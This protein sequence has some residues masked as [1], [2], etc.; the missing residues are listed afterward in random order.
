MFKNSVLL[1]GALVVAALL[2]YQ[3]ID[4]G[5]SHAEVAEKSVREQAHFAA[6][7]YTRNARDFLEAKLL[8]PGLEVTAKAGGSDPSVVL[9]WSEWEATSDELGWDPQSASALF[10]AGLR[11]EMVDVATVAADTAFAARFASWV[12]NELPGQVALVE[13]EGWEPVL[14][15]IP[16]EAASVAYRLYPESRAEATLAYG[17]RVVH[18][19]LSTA[20]ALAFAEGPLLPEAV[21]GGRANAALFFVTV[22]DAEGRR[23]WASDSTYQS[24]YV[25]RDTVGTKFGG[26]TTSV[27]VNPQ[28]AP[29]LVIGGLPRQRLPLVFALLALSVGLVATA[30]VQMRR[31]SE[32]AALRADFV[33]G[34]SHELRTPLAQIRMFSETLLLGRVRSEEERQRSLEIIVN[35]SQRLTHQVDNVLLYSRGERQGTRFDPCPL[36]LD[37]LVSEVVEGFEP[38]AHA[39][40]SDLTL[41]GVGRVRL[42][43]DGALVRQ[44]LLNLLDNAVKYGR[45]EQVVIVGVERSDAGGVRI[46]VDDEGPGVSEGERSR[47]FQPYHRLPRDRESAVAGSGIGLAV[48]GEV[49]RVHGGRAWVE[50]GA[51]GGARFVIELPESLVER[52]PGEA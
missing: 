3:A 22:D 7:Q 21:T 40:G 34:V 33:S 5:R 25:A 8:Y 13:A 39:A 45:E 18:D 38:L 37:E 23:V 4:A 32:L 36:D 52:A 11:S 10:R 9:S 30:L 51:R 26:L 50:R 27:V 6:W 35:E 43:L 29:S 1:F 44:A 49:A 48:V 14:A 31:E 2:A 16:G 41:A 42:A 24:E 12:R 19:R 17:F 28:V 20:L 46:W 47:I 15:P